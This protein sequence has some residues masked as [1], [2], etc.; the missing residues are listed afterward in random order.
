MAFGLVATQ[1]FFGIFNPL[2]VGKLFPL[3]DV[4]IYFSDGVFDKLVL[5]D[6]PFWLFKMT[7]G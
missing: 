5:K 7:T 3:F 2:Y 4:R 6:V 1:I